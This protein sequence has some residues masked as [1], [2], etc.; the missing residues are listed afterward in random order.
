MANPIIPATLEPLIEQLPDEAAAR[1]FAERLT[2][3][4]PKIAERLYRRPEAFSWALTLAAYSTWIGETLLQ[5]PEFLSWLERDIHLQEMRAFEDLREELARLAVVHSQLEPSVILSRFKRREWTRIYLRDCLRLC[6][7]S[8]LTEE[9]SHTADAI[10]DYAVEYCRSVLIGR[11]GMPLVRDERNRTTPARFAILAL[12]K[13]GSR[14]LNYASDIDLM[15]IFSGMGETEGGRDG[16]LRNRE[17]FTRLAE[18]LLRV[19][20]SLT[21]PEGAA[22]RV[23]IRLRPR[24]RDGALVVAVGEAEHYYRHEAQNWERLAMLR[25]RGCAGDLE[26]A[27]EFMHSIRDAIYWAEPLS[28]ALRDVRLSKEKIDRRQAE[29]S[30]GYNVKLGKGGIREIEFIAQALQVSHGGQDP[31]LRVPQTVIALQRLAE[32]GYLTE[33]ERTRLTEAYTFL[34]NCEHRIQMEQGAQTHNVPLDEEKLGLLARRMGYQGPYAARMFAL[35]LA[36]QRDHV[37]AVYQRIFSEI[38]ADSTTGPLV[39]TPAA[40]PEEALKQSINRMLAMP[41]AGILPTEQPVWESLLENLTEHSTDATRILTALRNVL[42]SWS[43]YIRDT[44]ARLEA[45]SPAMDSLESDFTTRLIHHEEEI[46]AWEK[47]LRLHVS[48]ARHIG[49]LSAAAGNELLAF[50][51]SGEFFTGL[52]NRHPRLLPMLNRPPLPAEF[53]RAE[54]F[55]Q[56]NNMLESCRT[57]AEVMAALRRVHTVALLE[58]G[59]ADVIG[60]ISLRALNLAQTALAEA[61]LDAACGFACK[62]LARQYE[63]EHPMPEWVIFGLGRLGHQ[64]LDY[65]SD[66]DVVIVY[67]E[68]APA[69][70]PQ[71][72]AAQAVMKMV[73]LV[74]NLLAALTSEGMLYR[75]DLRLRPDGRNGPTATGKQ[76]FL[77]YVQERAAGWE[78]LAYL[79]IRPVAGQVEQGAKLQKQILETIFARGRERGAQLQGETDDIRRRLQTER[80]GREAQRDFKFGPGGMVDVYFITRYLQIRDAVPDPPTY[81]TIALIEHLRKNSS[82]ETEMAQTLTSGYGFL[83]KLDHALRLLSERRTSRL[84]SQTETLA[85]LLKLPGSSVFEEEYAQ[86]TKAIR[87]C[88][89]HV[90]A[91]PGK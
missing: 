30:G 91:E 20:G 74:S 50:C 60:G 70:T 63:F 7:L 90:F 62:E 17:F 25:A 15:F 35:A 27:E 56:F 11:Y 57:T 39:R 23:D 6:T 36:R 49:V 31:W 21:S 28:D 43:A 34:R 26:L 77:Q 2:A 14:E 12:G 66:L 4:H 8:E 80:G 59:R 76:K 54:F 53:S 61:A 1:R 75:L 73:E 3:E 87:A 88:Y 71:F 32:K 46:P 19:V 38:K 81:G 84:P 33:A 55:R 45:E 67:D 44:R 47:D 52:L 37:I 69:P 64:G 13:L 40:T 48:N 65:G 22:F 89:Q 16:Q 10:L 42:A 86:Q 58:I 85:R 83:R 51:E 5:R 24:G 9:L 79:K 29:R 68:A 41:D 72:T 18:H 82:L 78:H